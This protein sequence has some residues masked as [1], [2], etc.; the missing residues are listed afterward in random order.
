MTNNTYTQGDPRAF[1]ERG[2]A[3]VNPDTARGTASLI[4]GIC[5]IFAGW[6]LLAPLI[7]LWLGIS[8]KK[9]EPL[10]RTRANWGIAL[11]AI[12]LSV[13]VVFLII[14]ATGLG[15]GFMQS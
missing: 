9:K 3:D 5:S 14:I 11:N 15:L 2:A 4:I 10:A 8:S 7:G 12:L 6:I 1:T 13:W